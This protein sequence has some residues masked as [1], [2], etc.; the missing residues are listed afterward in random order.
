VGKLGRILFGVA[1]L[2]FATL[3]V[4]YATHRGGP[5]P[6]PP[7]KPASTTL[8][9]VT[10]VVLLITG[11]C[12]AT[13]RLARIAAGVLSALFL[14]HFAFVHFPEL[15]RQ[16]HNPGPWT[17]SF[18]ILGLCGGAMVMAVAMEGRSQNSIEAALT[19]VGCLF[20]AALMIVVG[21]Q[22]FLYA[23]FVST[24]IPG[25][26]PARVFLAY[27]VGVAFFAVALSMITHVMRHLAAMLVGIMF[28]I[29]VAILHAPRVAHMLNNGNE[30]TS[31][32]VA[33]AMAGGSFAIAAATTTAQPGRAGRGR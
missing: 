6:G 21:V 10:A 20:F 33:L 19:N 25:W 28:V 15:V 8:S 30:W 29:F 3:Y 32:F 13:D 24:L 22:H 18:E 1:M 16:L 23:Q 11:A 4:I 12:L 7:W 17:S 31:L 2:G 26:I 9:Y 5:I 14:F 27:F